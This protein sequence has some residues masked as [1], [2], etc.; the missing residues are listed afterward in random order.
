MGY[1]NELTDQLDA[2]RKFLKNDQLIN[3]EFRKVNINYV[4]FL[5]DLVK[6]KENS[7][8]VKSEEFRKKLAETDTISKDWLLEKLDEIEKK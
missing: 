4:K 1:M 5:T 3:D 2:F 8:R 7:G 6:L